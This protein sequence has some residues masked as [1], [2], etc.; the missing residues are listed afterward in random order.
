M[1]KQLALFLALL[2]LLSCLAGCSAAVQQEQKPTR[3]FTDSCG[4]TVE[5]PEKIEHIVPSGA[6]AQIVLYTV[7]PE[8]LQSWAAALTKT[9]KKYI[10]E[11]YW[12]LPV[13]GQYYGGS[14]TFNLEEVLSSAPDVIVDVGER[15]DGIADD[16]AQLQ[17]ATGIPCVFIEGS[18]D[19]MEEAYR[20]LGELTGDTEQANACADYIGQ[21]LR[22]AAE[23]TAQIPEN[24]RMRV[25]Y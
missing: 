8:K 25:L 21:T 12:D 1:K 23:K 17:E 16:M 11:Q 10:P 3:P 14:A 19:T 18:L 2:L 5:V 6:L 15:K 4:R 9:Q 13:T 22:E 20:L 7:C 24:K